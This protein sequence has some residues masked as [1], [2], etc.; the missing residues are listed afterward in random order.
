MVIKSNIVWKFSS[1]NRNNAILMFASQPKKGLS[2][3]LSASQPHVKPNEK[4]SQLIFIVSYFLMDTISETSLH[5]HDERPVP[6]PYPPA[7]T[8][9]L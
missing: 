2:R 4:H 3:A 6:V 8:Q 1:K 7:L 5:R 9:Q